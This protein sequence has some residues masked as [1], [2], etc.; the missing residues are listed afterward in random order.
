MDSYHVM[1]N[2]L[3]GERFGEVKSLEAESPLKAA[4]LALDGMVE[5]PEFLDMV[6][7]VVNL[8]N[9]VTFRFIAHKS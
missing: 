5:I 9:K 2:S 7:Y 6:V 8:R 4:E 3:Q 1:V